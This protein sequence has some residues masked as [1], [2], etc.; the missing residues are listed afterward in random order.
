MDIKETEAMVVLSTSRRLTIAAI[1]QVSPEITG[2]L[3]A[4]IARS[5]LEI[6]GPWVFVARN[7]PRDS[8]TEF[9]LRFCRPVRRAD[10]YDGPFAVA[11]LEP[12][13][14]ASAMHQGSMRTLFTEGYAPL[15]AAIEASRHVFSGESREI[16]HQWAGQGGRYHRIEIQ[17]GLDY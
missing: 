3:D 17:F 11:H 5:G 1:K 6:A 7:L 8:K 4:E 9:E 14:V 15:V 16:Y 13:M 12:I 2:Q 10:G